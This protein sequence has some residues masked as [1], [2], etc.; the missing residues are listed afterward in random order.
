LNGAT[1]AGL[2]SPLNEQQPVIDGDHE[3]MA[4]LPEQV[5]VSNGA[6]GICTA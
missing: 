2:N 5:M 1:K 4:W 3:T 6:P